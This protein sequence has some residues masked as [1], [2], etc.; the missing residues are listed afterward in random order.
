MLK[1]HACTLLIGALA[2]HW[3]DPSAQALPNP[4]E[5]KHLRAATGNLCSTAVLVDTNRK[6][7]VL[8][9]RAQMV[10]Y[11]IITSFSHKGNKYVLA[12]ST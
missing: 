12:V 9:G 3:L 1:Q 4:T 5:L 6:N 11:K 7:K 8:P 2:D 10:M